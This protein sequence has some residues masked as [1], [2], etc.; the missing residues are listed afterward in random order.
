MVLRSGSV[1]TRNGK[2]RQGEALRQKLKPSPPL[3]IAVANTPQRI[4]EML[5]AVRCAN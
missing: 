1:Y 2:R 3:T 5:Q 4:W